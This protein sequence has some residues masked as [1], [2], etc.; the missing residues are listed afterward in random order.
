ML[1]TQR[2]NLL[3]ILRA[4]EWMVYTGR[5]LEVPG[6]PTRYLAAIFYV[7][8]HEQG[9]LANKEVTLESLFW[10]T[11]C[12]EKSDPLDGVYALLGMLT[13]Q[14]P[15]FTVDYTLS[16]SSLLIK[17][18]RYW[19]MQRNDLDMF[20]LI[21][22][23]D[24]HSRNP[25]VPTWVYRADLSTDGK[26]DPTKLSNV[27]RRRNC[28]H[29]PTMLADEKFGSSALLLEG[30]VLDRVTVTASDTGSGALTDWL[31]ESLRALNLNTNVPRVSQRL[32]ELATT[33]MCATAQ[34]G[35]EVDQDVVAILTRYLRLLLMNPEVNEGGNRA[36]E[37]IAA[38]EAVDRNCRFAY[39]LHRK[40]A[41]TA[42]GRSVLGS[43]QM[44]P[45][46]K[47]V[48]LRGGMAP[49]LLRA[50]GQDYRFLGEIYVHGLMKG[51]GD[52]AIKNHLAKGHKEQIFVVR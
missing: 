33:I 36:E 1:G 30:L 22:H 6:V 51:D 49:C 28:L 40:L 5:Y 41:L 13:E 46:D 24:F 52:E 21:S 29:R 17:V 20:T 26:V 11:R 47:I 12:L 23:R 48:V 43:K 14:P 19:L 4:H 16:L 2:I 10:T 50:Y 45:G 7:V 15:P 9:Y 37:Q 42:A 27:V 31:L 44:S 32:S 34:S 25:D 3:D 39:A 35:L 8:D 18:S 38:E